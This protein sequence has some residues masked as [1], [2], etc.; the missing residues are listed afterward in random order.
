MINYQALKTISLLYIRFILK[1]VQMGEAHGG[2]AFH[3]FLHIRLGIILLNQGES[4]DDTFLQSQVRQ[5]TQVGEH[6][7]SLLPRVCRINRLIHILDVDHIMVH[8]IHRLLEERTRLVLGGASRDTTEFGSMEEGLF[9][10]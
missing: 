7:R 5:A 4:D 2:Q 9:S 6:L 8:H 10:S 3:A 1:T